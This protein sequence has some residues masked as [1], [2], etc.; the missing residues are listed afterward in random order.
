VLAIAAP[1]FALAGWPILGFVVGAAVW[2]VQAFVQNRLQTRIDR[3]DDPR[4]VIGLTAGGSIGRAW[5]TAIVILLAGLY[6]E[7]VGLSA[8]LLVF[9]AFTVYFL[10]AV[11]SRAAGIGAGNR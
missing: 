11:V 7:R 10:N 2:L 4:A 6:D 8:L 3:S 1:T 5:F 9:A